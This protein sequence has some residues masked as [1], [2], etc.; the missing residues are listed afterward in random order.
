MK[1]CY[2]TVPGRVGVSVLFKSPCLNNCKW[3]MFWLWVLVMIADGFANASIGIV[4][5]V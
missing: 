5:P 3:V 2:M 1:L 4:T